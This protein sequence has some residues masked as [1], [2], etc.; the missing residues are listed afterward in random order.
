MSAP[1]LHALQRIHRLRH[2]PAHGVCRDEAHRLRRRAA[3]QIQSCIGRRG[4]AG[5][6]HIG[7]HLQIVRRQEAAA[8]IDAALEEAPDIPRQPGQHPNIL[9]AQRLCAPDGRLLQIRK[10]FRCYGK[11]RRQRRRCRN[12]RRHQQSRQCKDRRR[13]AGHRLFSGIALRIGRGHPVQQMPPAERQPPQRA[14]NR[15]RRARRRHGQRRQLGSRPPPRAVAKRVQRRR[16]V[17]QN[18]ARRDSAAVAHPQ[19]LKQ[20]PQQRRRAETS[21]QI[22]QQ[23]HPLRRRQ[24]A[25]VGRIALRAEQHRQQLP[26][27]AGP[28]VQAAQKSG[29]RGGKAV[30]EAHVA[31]QRRPRQRALDQI[32]AENASLR[33]RAVQRLG[34]SPHI[35]ETLSAVDARAGHILPEVRNRRRIGIQTALSGKQPHKGVAAGAGGH[36]HLGLQ[37]RIAP[38]LAL[39]GARR[40]QRM[41]HRTDQ[42][43]NRAGQKP[44][45]R[46][47]GQHIAKPP[48][49]RLAGCALRS[50]GFLRA[51]LAQQEPV[52]VHQRAALAVA[53]HPAMIGLKKPPSPMQIEILCPTGA[54]VHLPNAPAHALRDLLV[55]V[56][57]LLVRIGKIAENQILYVFILL[58]TAQR[59]KLAADFLRAAHAGQ[60]H[61]HDHQRAQ[62]IRHAV[63]LHFQ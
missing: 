27:A 5:S 58:K 6:A 4:S 54:G 40:V 2:P 18:H 26:V 38:V 28:A 53:A 46:V 24:P 9:A 57:M 13:T 15:V 3:H 48:L 37:H 12:R 16:P 35:I 43:L 47:E 8:L 30:V 61:R 22:V 63:D 51:V 7:I 55:A 50:E 36:L 41:R 19:A 49:Q 39:L 29:Q 17:G 33:Q 23:P 60:Q 59:L 34:K 14:Q 20:Q 25:A 1:L 44:G 31:D 11:H 56:D 21:Q 52:Q 42:P 45:V 32:V 10:P 62:F